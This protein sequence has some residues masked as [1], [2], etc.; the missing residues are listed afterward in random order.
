MTAY[1][2]LRAVAQLP[3]P[4]SQISSLEKGRSELLEVSLRLQRLEDQVKDGLQ[5]KSRTAL[6]AEI[7]DLS[8]EAQ[9]RSDVV[10]DLKR[11]Y[12]AAREKINH[13]RDEFERL[14]ATPLVAPN[15]V[16][17]VQR[18]PYWLF[19]GVVVT[20]AA[21]I[22]HVIN[23]NTE[24]R[25][26]AAQSAL[27]TLASGL[28]QEK[29]NLY[30]TGYRERGEDDPTPLDPTPIPPRPFDPNG[31]YGPWRGPGRTPN[32]GDTS[33]YS[34]GTRPPFGLPHRNGI[35]RPG[36]VVGDPRSG[37]SD[38]GYDSLAD[39]ERVRNHDTGRTSTY[40]A[41][42][43]KGEG[44]FHHPIN[45]PAKLKDI[46]PF[47]NPLN[48]RM[49]ADGKISGHLPVPF[50]RYWDSIGG[51]HTSP[52]GYPGAQAGI[53]ALPVAGGMAAIGGA[54]ALSRHLGGSSASAANP[55]FGQSG[56]GMRPAFGPG[57]AGGFGTGGAGG[58]GTGGAGMGTPAGAAG[59]GAAGQ[60]GSGMFGA[61]PG[62]AAGAGQS[63]KKAGLKGYQ[64][65]RVDEEEATAIG[66]SDGFGAGSADSVAPRSHSDTSDNWED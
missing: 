48:P 42:P 59:A 29:S 65:V 63:D 66:H 41:P 56:M 32:L 18:E 26:N 3:Y 49:T 6:L 39:Y 36:F 33:G 43:A 35:D 58:F 52:G 40:V 1:E 53:G 25:E 8:H 10:E 2:R 47:T 15:L 17:F 45:D 16:E 5:G 50:E 61:P 12:E 19:G 20:A 13:A 11:S 57:G 46:D 24:R 38:T 4:H 7:K 64:V 37:H 9:F 44:S 27:N 14:E 62:G 23:V 60:H 30:R 34:H 22:H 55:L 51:S 28:G 54:A 31:E 21:Y